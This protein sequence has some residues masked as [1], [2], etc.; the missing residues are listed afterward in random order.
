MRWIVFILAA[1]AVAAPASASPFSG[2]N[3]PKSAIRTAPLERPS[4]ELWL[5]AENLGEEVHLNIYK[6][7]GSFDDASLAKLDVLFRCPF[8]GN[9][10]AVNAE[11]Y[12]QL[13][14]IH[15]HFGKK[16]LD[17]VSGHRLTNERTS[18]RHYH[19]SAA[20]FH[21]VGVS[22]NEIR[23]YA[24]SLDLGHMGIG[25]YPTSQFVHVDF[26]AP[27]EPSFR[28][29]DYSGHS[30]PKKKSPGRTMPARKPTS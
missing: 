4:G 3:A 6:Q 18:S 29:V 9:V 17:L 15:D 16:R 8:S 21:I 20:D 22:I 2:Q 13:S 23:K 28:W 5:R 1:V 10:R 24:E 11:L 30:S 12:E 27:G 19:A 25:I 14:R 26:R 7:D